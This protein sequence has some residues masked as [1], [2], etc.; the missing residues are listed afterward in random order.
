MN[1]PYEMLLKRRT[2]R[3]FQSKAIPD[4]TLNQILLAGKFAPS[5]MGMQNRHF[6]VIQNQKLLDDIVAATVKNGG[7]FSPGHIPFYGAPDIVVLSAPKDFKYNR[8]DCACAIQNLMLAAYA[9]DIGSCYICSVLPGLC[10]NVI[11]EQLNLPQ[12]YVPCGCVSLGYPAVEA[13]E[14]KERRSGDISWI[15]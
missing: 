7:K 5:A 2:I 6:T 13:G 11:L 3:S 8:E 15:R 14:P 10:D 12:N 9:L 1:A 4:E